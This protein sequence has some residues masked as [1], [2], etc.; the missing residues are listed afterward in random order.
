MI[1]LLFIFL[2]KKEKQKQKDV[3]I[4]LE[5]ILKYISHVQ[6]FYMHSS[7]HEQEVN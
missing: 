6:L 7:K 3:F 1:K 5:H 2:C 4:K